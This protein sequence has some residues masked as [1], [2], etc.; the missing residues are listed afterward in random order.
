[1]KRIIGVRRRELPLPT[2]QPL[3]N[4]SAGP[5][6]HTLTSYSIG[7]LVPHA[8]SVV[9]EAQYSSQDYHYMVD[10]LS[11][12][13]WKYNDLDHSS[14]AHNLV[15]PYEG[16][17]TYQ[18]YVYPVSDTGEDFVYSVPNAH[19]VTQS[20]LYRNIYPWKV[21]AVEKLFFDTSL[22]VEI[23]LNKDPFDTNFSIWYL[24]TDLVL[25][26][27]LFKQVFQSG[28]LTRLRRIA[29][30]HPASAIKQI[31]NDYLLE[32]FGIKPTVDDIIEFVRLL[33]SWKEKYDHMDQLLNEEHVWRAAQLDIFDR[34]QDHNYISIYHA[35]LRDLNVKASVR[36]QHAYFNRCCRYK[37]AAPE[38]QG[39]LARLCQFIDA[40]GVL[41]PAAIWDTIPFSFVVDWFLGVGNF[42]HENRPRF[43]PAT[44][45]VTDYCESILLSANASWYIEGPAITA[46]LG[47]Y[48]IP[49]RELFV[50]S[51]QYT[52]FVRRRFC[53]RLANFTGLRVKSSS[54]FVKID[55][56]I[57]ASALLAQRA[58]P[59]H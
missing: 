4:I 35:P 11:H 5:L 56:A 31:A 58:L 14:V 15:Y 41:D 43:F 38:F 18:Y 45:N 13:R 51:Q 52:T 46:P 36:Y 47:E 40:F 57:V 48:P 7:S 20:S 19:I 23:P 39:W 25:L 24:I 44:I 21:E 3:L 27:S 29:R 54:S 1:M 30:R 55:H 49:D 59:R 37:F 16:N 34:V 33:S 9:R 8:P 2:D 50:G 17:D 6:S 10:V 42:L 28:R 22:P 12:G 26:K 32:K 53:P